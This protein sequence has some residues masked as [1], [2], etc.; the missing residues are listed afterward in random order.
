MNVGFERLVVVVEVDPAGLA[1]DVVAPLPRVLHDRLAAL[2]VE[3][4][5]A[6]LEDLLLGLDAELAHRLE[7]GGQPVGVPAEAALDP[8]AAHRLVA[9]DDVLDVA[10]EQ[11][12]VVRQPVGEG[13]AVVEDELVGAVL[14]RRAVRHRRGEGVVGRPGASTASSICG[15]PGARGHAEGSAGVLTGRGDLGVRHGAAPAVVDS[16]CPGRG[17]RVSVPASRMPSRS[18]PAVPPRLPPPWAMTA[19]VPG[20]DVTPTSGSSE[21]VTV[22]AVGPVLPEARR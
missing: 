21:D 11:V 15:E 19:L 18:P 13:R 20:R 1:G 8:A 2:G 22:D 7:L 16:S 3:G 9:G 6:E 12:A 14:A 17:R 4:L 10:G 5:D